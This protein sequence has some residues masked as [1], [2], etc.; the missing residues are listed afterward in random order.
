MFTIEQAK[1]AVLAIIKDTNQERFKFKIFTFLESVH[2]NNMFVKSV[3]ANPETLSPFHVHIE[4][5]AE[6]SEKTLVCGTSFAEFYLSRNGE[7]CLFSQSAWGSDAPVY[8]YLTAFM[9]DYFSDL[10]YTRCIE[11]NG[12]GKF[13]QHDNIVQALDSHLTFLHFGALSMHPMVICSDDL[14]ITFKYHAELPY[15]PDKI[16]LIVENATPSQLVMINA[17]AHYVNGRGQHR[18]VQVHTDQKV[19]A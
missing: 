1:D 15:W 5:G 11:S 8:E 12:V 14:K 18:L 7:G 19:A 2:A 16:D 10:T 17:V 13:T 9:V 6:G 3:N 4:I